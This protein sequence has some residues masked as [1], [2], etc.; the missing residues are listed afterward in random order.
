MRSWTV[1]DEEPL[2]V[3]NRIVASSDLFQEAFSAGCVENTLWE[4]GQSRDIV[5]SWD[6]GGQLTVLPHASI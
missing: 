1:R 4:Q 3:L 6:G 5:D 2:E